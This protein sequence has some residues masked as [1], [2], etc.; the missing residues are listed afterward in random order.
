MYM[1]ALVGALTLIAMT[2]IA[3]AQTNQAAFFRISSP[4][5]AVITGFYP[6]ADSAIEL[7][8]VEIQILEPIGS[9]DPLIP[10]TVLV[11]RNG[12]IANSLF[13]WL[14]IAGSAQNG[15]D[16]QYVTPYVNFSPGQ[17]AV[18][19]NMMPMASGVLDGGAET[20]LIEIVEDGAYALADIHS[21][22][23]ILAER[24]EY[25]DLWKDR[26]FFGNSDP[27]TVFA[28][29]DEG[30]LGIGNLARFAYG[31][32]PHAP[33][34]ALLPKLVIRDGR[35]QLDV[36]RNPGVMDVEFEVSVSTNLVDWDS[37]SLAVNK[38]LVPELEEEAGIETY[39]SA[40]PVLTIPNQFMRVRLIYSP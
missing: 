37:S 2:G 36:H 23:I 13:V 39:E 28:A 17:T 6:V 11:K 7:P 12:Q 35:C 10:A 14:R 30:N 3:T 21:A 31:L 25:L 26:E 9:K 27:V 1:K 38:I 5:N 20:V 34:A 16:Y 15:I 40:A 22:R 4:S 33:D 24:R 8:V 32:D 18:P 19:I 29:G